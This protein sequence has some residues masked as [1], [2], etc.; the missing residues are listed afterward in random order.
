MAT[1][2]KTRSEGEELPKRYKKAQNQLDDLLDGIRTG[3]VAEAVEKALLEPVNGDERPID[4]WSFR[5]RLLVLLSGTRDARGYC[6]WQNLGRQVVKGTEA[7][8][9]LAPNTYTKTV[10]REEEIEELRGARYA[11]EQEETSDGVKFRV[12][13]GFRA[14]PVF[15]FE[16]T[17]PIEGF[18]GEPYDPDAVNYAPP[19]LPPLHDV[20]DRLGIAVEYDAHRTGRGYGAYGH[21]DTI[22]LHTHDQQTW[23]H[24]LAHAAHD[25]VTD[26]DLEFGQ[27]PKQEAV[28]EVSAAVLSR[29]YGEPNDGYTAQYLD[30]YAGSQRDAYDLALEV[31]G[32]VEKVLRHVL[33]LAG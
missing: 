4:T 7:I 3:D 17:E 18:D 20:A 26:G 27:D 15:R 1:A 2:T 13:T 19:E 10:E 31:L 5:N 9:I 32:E 29:L 25:A 30:A 28:A 23:F 11:T 14:A 16:D 8:R 22:T 21:G 33:D 12:L 24:E 6:Q